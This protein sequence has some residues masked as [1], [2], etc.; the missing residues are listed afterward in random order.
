MAF[1]LGA[2]SS[3]AYPQPRWEDTRVV[4][5]IHKTER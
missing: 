1:P 5:L 2:E 4:R 3:N